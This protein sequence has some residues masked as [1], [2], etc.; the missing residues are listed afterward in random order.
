M[1]EFFYTG[2]WVSTNELRNGHKWTVQKLKEEYRKIYSILLI[3]AVRKCQFT[4]ERFDSFKIQILYNSRLDPDNVTLKFLCDAMKDCRLIIDDNKKYFRGF[5]IEPDETLP[6][7][8]YY[9]KIWQP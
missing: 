7:D 9:V 6:K 2:K 8:T 5:S 4:N 3:D 1:I